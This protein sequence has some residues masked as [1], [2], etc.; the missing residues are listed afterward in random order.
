LKKG[1]RSGSAGAGTLLRV[2][3]GEIELNLHSIIAEY[4]AKH[5]KSWPALH[6]LFQAAVAMAV[7]LGSPGVIA[8]ML[9]KLADEAEA[10]ASA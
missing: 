10:G 3:S 1:R 6:A 2:V 8:D 7:P 9:D 4:A 5:G